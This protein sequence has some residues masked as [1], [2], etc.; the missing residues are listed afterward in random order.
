MRIIDLEPDTEYEVK[1]RTVCDEEYHS[2]YSD[3]AIFRTDAPIPQD[4]NGRTN[5]LGQL[6][7]EYGNVN[8][9]ESY[10]GVLL[11]YRYVKWEEDG[12]AYEYFDKEDNRIVDLNQKGYYEVML[13]Y[14]Y[15][16][17][18]ILI[19]QLITLFG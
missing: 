10:H 8:G 17:A 4:V 13:K 12:W 14:D 5:G 9:F 7:V 16:D 1:V 2:L 3:I 15:T 6:L 18:G 19:T 11:K